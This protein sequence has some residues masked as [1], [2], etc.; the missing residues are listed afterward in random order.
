MCRGEGHRVI[1][2]LVKSRKARDK[3][4]RAYIEP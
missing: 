1:M 4:K 3:F 2:R